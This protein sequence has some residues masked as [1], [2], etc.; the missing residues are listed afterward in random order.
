[1]AGPI[2]HVVLAKKALDSF[3]KHDSKEFIVGTLLPDI[4]YLNV[5]D[6]KTTHSTNLT[7]E[8]VSQEPDGF[9]AGFLFHSLVD[10]KREAY[11]AQFRP[12]S[13]L[14]DSHLAT[15]ALKVAED[16]ALYKRLPDW[17]EI[18]SFFDDIL[19]Q[20]QMFDI[21]EDKLRQ[22]HALHQTLF[23]YDSP[24]N[25]PDFFYALGFTSEDFVELVR[26]VRRIEERG[27][28][29]AYVDGLYEDLKDILR[30]S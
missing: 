30:R 4:R 10:E 19:P 24:L 26:L 8:Q 11:I 28:I 15:V 6:R 25:N 17:S 12:Y 3:V 14:P 23:T 9:Q 20:E 1:M 16:Q 21:Q 27:I 2:T 22:W 29:L 5:V 18:I 7:Y 13:N